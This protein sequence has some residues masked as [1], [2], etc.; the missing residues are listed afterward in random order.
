MELNI[1]IVD[2]DKRLLSTLTSLLIE[3]NHRVVPCD[4]GLDAIRKCRERPFDLVIT[5]LMMPGA[6]G[7]D[8][9]RETRKV[10]P[11]TLVVLVTG[12]ASLES[13]IEAIR[14]GA[15]DYLAKPFKLEEIKILIQ[16]ASERIRLARENQRLLAELQEAY[17]Q[18]QTVKEI[19]G[20]GKGSPVEAATGEGPAQTFIAGSMLPLY[21]QDNRGG[22]GPMF[23]ADLER[24][25]VLKE[26]GFLTEEEFNL[27]KSKMLRNGQS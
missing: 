20:I 11:S 15:Y 6:S 9:L 25:S 19:M 24:L 22:Q 21:Y 7:L 13:A 12:F 1:L 16:N 8:V 2:D 4:N 14:E 17:A 18:L 3:E 27:C 23:V 26:K 5:D 10:S